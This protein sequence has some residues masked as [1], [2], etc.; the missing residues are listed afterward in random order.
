MAHHKSARKRARQ[1]IKRRARNRHVLGTVRT[2]LKKAH[3]AVAGDDPADAQ[4]AVRNAESQLRRAA[5]RGVIPKTRA[6]RQ[7]SRLARLA[8]RASS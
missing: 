5:S 1:S 4:G 2:A 6:S 3:A 8:H 7:I